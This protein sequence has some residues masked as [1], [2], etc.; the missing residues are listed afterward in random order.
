MRTGVSEHS[1]RHYE[2]NSQ[3]QGSAIMSSLSIDNARSISQE[4]SEI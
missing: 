2:E 1:L 3:L 4:I